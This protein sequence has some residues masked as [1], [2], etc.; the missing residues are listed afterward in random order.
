MRQSLA[1]DC[2][3][4]GQENSDSSP[5]VATQTRMSV[6]RD[7][8]IA[9]VQGAY[10]SADGHRIHVCNQ[11]S[12]GCSK[13]SGQLQHEVAL[14]A[15]QFGFLMGSVGLERIGAHTSLGKFAPNERRHLAFVST[16]P[17]DRNQ[18]HQ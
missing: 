10:A 11:E 5:I 3:R 17:R 8:A 14:L 12:A 9:L 4:C 13:S 2:Y 1:H 18:A 6:S 7:D 16:H 15:S